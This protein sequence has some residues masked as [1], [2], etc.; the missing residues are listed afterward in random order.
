LAISTPFVAENQETR[1]L[2]QELGWDNLGTSMSYYGCSI[3]RIDLQ[4]VDLVTV[5]G[6]SIKLHAT[7]KWK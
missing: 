2:M 7:S 5:R 1:F 6:E 4:G 3:P